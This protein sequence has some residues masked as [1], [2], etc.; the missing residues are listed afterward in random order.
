[1]TVSGR[2]SDVEM[3]HDGHPTLHHIPIF[4]YP[5]W[6][7]VEQVYAEKTGELLESDKVWKARDREMAKMADH[8]VKHDITL[9]ECQRR[10]M[11][12]VRSR[13]V[14]VRKALP[15]DPNGVRSRLVAQEINQGP[16]D[17]TFAGTPPLWVHRLIVASAA[18]K[19]KADKGLRRLLARYD[20]SV[21]FF[22]APSSGGICV[23]PPPDMFDGE[24]VWEL[25]K[26]MNG[27]REASKR[28]AQF[29]QV[30]LVPAGFQVSAAIPNLYWHPEWSI[31]VACHGDDFL[32]E[33]LP[34]DLDRLDELMK[35]SFEVK[36]LPRIGDPS[37]G[38]EVSEGS[39]LN[40]I[41]RWN[42]NGFSWEADPKHSVLLTQEL[43]LD[44]SKGVETPSCK[45]TGKN[46]RDVEEPLD[47]AEAKQFRHWT[48]MALYL[49]LDRPSI[50][51]AA[52]QCSSGMA[53]PT[54]LH[55]LQLKRLVRYLVKYPKEVWE[56]N[57]Q[58]EPSAVQVYSDSDWAT[59]QRT[60]KSMSCYAIRFGEHLLDTSCARQSTVALSS[61]E[62]EYYALTRGASAGLLVK[63]V[64]AELGREV[65]LDCLTDSSA[66][67]GITARRG[68]GKVK[69]LDL[70]E[71]WLQDKAENKELRVLKEGTVTN[72]ADIGT[73]A[74]DGSRIAELLQ[75]MP[76]KRG[77][78]AAFC[79][80]GAAAQ[81]ERD[82]HEGSWLWYFVLIYPLASHLRHSE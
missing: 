10:G 61:G 71:L 47:P 52:S 24:H 48:G 56:Y 30:K 40:R 33:G 25:D 60:R 19:R 31:T 5:E 68:V 79:L 20:V 43:K 53:A 28:W 55:M 65:K 72:W 76:L 6:A 57:L 58:D 74:L 16:R 8:G 62:A 13:W 23:K 42:S 11:K 27:T 9:A 81:G 21:A 12:L 34:H 3:D 2:K 4:A 41:I 64:L 73:K 14:D 26:A 44:K 38:G 70:R 39:H 66:A 78:I 51:F 32:A 45:E 67:K 1:M 17:D 36:V 29:I 7:D 35:A 49:S 80:A 15:D 75:L 82:G 54:R 69:H 46:E 37:Y 63:D 50:Q 18:T 22:H 77:V 59:C